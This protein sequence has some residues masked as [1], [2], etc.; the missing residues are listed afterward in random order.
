MPAAASGDFNLPSNK[1]IKRD[2]AAL[3]GKKV[4]DVEMICEKYKQPD[5]CRNFIKMKS[6][7][8]HMVLIPILF[9][10]LIVVA[11]SGEITVKCRSISNKF[12]NDDT[13]ALFTFF[14]M[15]VFAF[16]GLLMG[17]WF[18]LIGKWICNCLFTDGPQ[19]TFKTKGVKAAQDTLVRNHD[20]AYI[21]TGIFWVASINVYLLTD[22]NVSKDV[23]TDAQ[24]SM[25]R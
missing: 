10:Y 12:K 3:N 1:Q 4:D 8:W 7:N 5:R 24:Q 15:E 19:F 17:L 2:D 6:Y 9:L 16:G 20:D 13:V 14:E 22:L 21:A 25:I 23:M 18:W 11:E